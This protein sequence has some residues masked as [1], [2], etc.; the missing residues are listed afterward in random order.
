MLNK[1]GEVVDRGRI[2]TTPKA[3]AKKF[4]DLPST[5]VAALPETGPKSLSVK[6]VRHA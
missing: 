3:I 1:D 6:T 2:R 4:T 5:R